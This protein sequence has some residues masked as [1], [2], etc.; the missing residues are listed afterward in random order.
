MTYRNTHP[1]SL[2][3]RS[4]RSLLLAALTIALLAPTGGRAD[5]TTPP[6]KVELAAPYSVRAS[7]LSIRPPLES[8]L[9]VVGTE[10]SA[11]VVIT[12]SD[13]LWRMELSLL[14]VTSSGTSVVQVLESA[15]KTLARRPTIL[16]RR[17]GMLIQGRKAEMAFV[18][19]VTIGGAE[20]QAGLCAVAVSPTRFAVLKMVTLPAE[21]E[22]ARP[23]FEQVAATIDY[24]DPRDEEQKRQLLLRRG[25]DL[26]DERM[27]A[28]M[29][30][31][32]AREEW[33]RLYTL[34]TDGG[35]QELGYVRLRLGTG[36]RGE[37]SGSDPSRYSV[38][39]KE[40][41]LTAH[42]AARYL[43][44]DGG[45]SDVV[46]AYFLSKDRRTEDW[47]TTQTL[48]QEDGTSTVTLIGARQGT[49][50]T[51]TFTQNSVNYNPRKIVVP[52]QG[53][54]SQVELY[55]LPL[56]LPRS[57]QTAE[58][59]FWYFRESD[60]VFRQDK[61]EPWTEEPGLWR[62]VSE[63]SSQTGPMETIVEPSGAVRSKRT[64]D[65]VR[66]EATSLEELL[67]LWRRKGLPID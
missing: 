17:E 18:G 51:A 45:V 20:A 61:T 24:A 27:P 58:V 48:R 9:R 62:W 4:W 11:Q 10:S 15:L 55:L 8:S 66:W 36:K 38:S 19:G 46:A 34:S 64:A 65:G 16:E 7:G 31:L 54:L 13:H 6:E 59:G 49:R 56:L 52:S 25:Q 53:Y 50:L 67:T 41:G 37:V 23:I 43:P 57:E 30:S 40:Q 63:I 1:C 33:F 60:V 42:L 39:E 22:R 3:G 26:L 21:F 44:P 5:D 14:E 12:P 35:E 32:K 28:L 47:K 2:I 29:T